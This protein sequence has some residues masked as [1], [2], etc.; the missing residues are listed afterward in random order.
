MKDPE[1]YTNSTAFPE[2]LGGDDGAQVRA[3][4]D[5]VLNFSANQVVQQ[6]PDAETQAIKKY[7]LNTE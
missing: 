7:V 3:L 4:R 1:G 6:L 2:I 5:Y